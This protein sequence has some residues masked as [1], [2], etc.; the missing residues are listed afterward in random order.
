MKALISCTSSVPS[1]RRIAS[2]V[3]RVVLAALRGAA[4]FDLE[5][6]QHA[7][8]DVAAE[9]DHARAVAGSQV[10]LEEHGAGAGVRPGAA[11]G[12][13]DHGAA[14][15]GGAD[16][17]AVVHHVV[18]ERSDGEAGGDDLSAGGVVDVAENVGRCRR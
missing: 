4:E 3:E 14:A 9:V 13:E 18:K 10:A 17:G 2:N 1:R 11:G 8:V 15:R 5:T 16:L 7:E 6:G 12:A